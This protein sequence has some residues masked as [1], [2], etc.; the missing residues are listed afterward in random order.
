[1]SPLISE[2]GTTAVSD[3]DKANVLNQFFSS[4]YTREEKHNLP[5][6]EEA[7]RSSGT[8]I[9]DICITPQ[10]VENKLKDLNVCKAQ[11]PDGIPARVLKELSHEL[12]IPLSIVFNK[13]IEEGSIPEDWKKAHVIPIFKKGTRTDPGNYRPVSLTCIICKVLESIV[14]D[15]IVDHMNKNE[16]FSKCQH[17]FRSHRSCITQLL[18][19]IEDLTQALEDHETVDIIYLDFKKAFDSVPHERL[20][21]KLLSYGIAGPVL[22]WIRD[23]LTHRKQKVRVNKVFSKESD[24]LSGIPQGSILGPILFT[25]FINDLPDCV[26]STCKIFADDTKLY[27]NPSKS[28]VLQNDL[29]NLQHWSEKWNLYFNA[30][31]CKVLHIGKNNPEK[32]CYEKRR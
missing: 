12:A 9:I 19:V 1:M 2:S 23:F 25:M 22:R 10:A 31:K 28:S 30:K 32:D 14:R 7:S 3:E 26:D 29:D 4:V 18:E 15:V 11:G 21:I 20:L 8:T 5:D 24:V 27:N 17:G 13:S 16:L 6:R